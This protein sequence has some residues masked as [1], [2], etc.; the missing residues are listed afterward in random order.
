M[1]RRFV[2]QFGEAAEN[3][4][5]SML[6][7]E[8]PH[9]VGKEIGNALNASEG[10]GTRLSALGNGMRICLY[11]GT[12]LPKVGGAEMVVDQ[13]A[14]EWIK[15]G[16]DVTVLAPAPSLWNRPDDTLYP[17][18]VV[19]HL[20]F[21]S[22]RIGVEWY[23]R[24]LLKEHRKHR[25]DVIHCHGLY[26]HAY[27]ATRTK[28]S[29]RVPIAF[30]SHGGD[31]G[32]DDRRYSKP[33]VRERMLWT[34]SQ[35]DAMISIGPFTREGFERLCPTKN[36]RIEDI[37]NGVAWQ[38]YARSTAPPSDLPQDLLPRSYALFLGRLADRKGVDLLLKALAEVPRQ[39]K[40]DL[41]IAGDGQ[42]RSSL[43]ELA[44]ELR[45]DD[46]VRFVGRVSGTKKIYLLQNAR[47]VVMPSRRWEALPLVLLESFAA[48]TP[49]L[50]TNTPGLAGLIEPGRNGMLVPA[51]SVAELAGEMRR[52]FASP[53]DM[54]RL[55]RQARQQ[56]QRQGWD[57]IAQRHLELFDDLIR[58]KQR[59][60]EVA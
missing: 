35:L 2:E 54:A 47:F 53:E 45:I 40:V 10:V 60:R 57:A 29:L 11:V 20:P 13:L 52:A 42:L 15:S 17:Y 33:K 5:R 24:Y 19:R 4:P 50:G 23:G 58:A 25:F 32:P 46:R 36:V 22:S 14:R 48:G 6:L 26:P 16:Q 3:D 59:L 43:E 28:G 1:F 39:N 34:M 51:E 37:P 30:T 18:R 49:V 8:S 38:E 27:L 21:F 44:R 31:V 12:A 55:G 41:V 9:W 7:R 56:A